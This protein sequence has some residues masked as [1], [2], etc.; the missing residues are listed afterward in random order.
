M[1]Q[2]SLSTN[3]YTLK[4]ITSFNHA[5]ADVKI[6]NVHPMGLEPATL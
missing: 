6:F 5:Q 3:E 4:C 2:R 1:T